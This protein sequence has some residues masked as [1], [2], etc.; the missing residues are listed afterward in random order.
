[1]IDDVCIQLETHNFRQTP[2]TRHITV[3]FVLVNLRDIHILT[4]K[5]VSTKTK[6]RKNP[7]H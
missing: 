3:M 6:S 4:P 2:F 5:H 7:D 1:M